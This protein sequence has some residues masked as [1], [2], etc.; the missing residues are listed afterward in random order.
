MIKY[1]NNI[2]V[3]RYIIYIMYRCPNEKVD[4]ALFFEL[5]K[6]KKNIY[7]LKFLK[8]PSK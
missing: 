2:C 3:I 7:F 5:K 1:N 6:T 4:T 8:S